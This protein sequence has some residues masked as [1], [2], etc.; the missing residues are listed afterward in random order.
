VSAVLAEE[1]PPTFDLDHHPADAAELVMCLRD[2]LWRLCSGFLYKIIVKSESAETGNVVMPF[3]PNAAQMDFIMNLWHRNL[4]LKARQLGFTTL[5]ALMWLDHALFNANQ[6]CGIIAQD[7]DTAAVIFRDKVRFAYLN[8]P[9]DLR[10]Q[11]P[12]GRD[13]ASE[14]LFAHNNSSIRVATSVRGGTLHRLHVSEFGKIGAKYPAKAEEVVTGSLPA[15]PTDGIAIIESTAEGQE[16]H[17][18][19]MSQKAE[20]DHQAKRRLSAKD[21]RFHFYPWHEN[22]EYS[23]EPRGVRITAKDHEYFHKVE[24]WTGRRLSMRQRAWYCVTRDSEFSGDPA[25]MWREY[26]STP[27]EAFQQSTEGTYYATQL[28]AA[29]IAGRIGRVPYVEGVPVNT[30]WDIG[31]RDG[32]A[33]WLHQRIGA[34]HRLIGFMEAWGEPYSYFVRQL[35]AT[36]YVWG[37]HNLP[38]DA[39]QKRQQGTVIRTPLDMLEELTPG[40]RWNIVPRVDEIQTGIQATRALFGQCWFD[41]T[42]C[43]E[44][45]AH[46]AGYRKTWDDRLGVWRNEPRH[47]IHSEAADAFRQLA[48]G[49]EDPATPAGSRP[50]RRRRG[51]MAV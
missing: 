42:A 12:L 3:R 31:N 13:S 45:L 21:Y 50:K 15:V 30:W 41:E 36:G 23:I 51:G 37:T 5:I 19:K 49:W 25:L 32:T 28:A 10:V 20:A 18:F 17:F 22:P 27:A 44:G 2:P 40:W 48:Q 33:L 9:D 38:H 7:K 26:P 43:K 47:D 39:L 34:E 11:M 16:G 29:R 46:L 6:R 4:I 24:A 8:L 35:Q 1:P 14:L